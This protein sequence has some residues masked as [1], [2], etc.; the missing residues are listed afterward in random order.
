MK[1]IRVQVRGGP[2]T[3]LY[4]I[5]TQD[6]GNIAAKYRMQRSNST[7]NQIYWIQCPTCEDWM[8]TECI[9]NNVC[10]HDRTEL[11]RSDACG[12]EFISRD[13]VQRTSVGRIFAKVPIE[14]MAT[15]NETTP[16]M[17]GS[18]DGNHV[19]CAVY[20]PV[21]PVSLGDKS[22]TEGKGIIGPELPKDAGRTIGPELPPG[23]VTDD[24]EE[25]DCY[26][27]AL[28]PAAESNDS[29]RWIGPSL[30]PDLDLGN[31]QNFGPTPIQSEYD[32]IG[33]MPVANVDKEEQ[34]L[35]YV[36]RRLELESKNAEEHKLVREEWI[37]KMPKQGPIAG[38]T[39]RTFKRTKDTS[40][41][42]E[43]WEDTPKT[44]RVMTQG[45]EP[46]SGYQ[47]QKKA[48]T[49]QEHESSPHESLVEMH[50]KKREK[51][52]G[53]KLT[54]NSGERVPFNRDQDMGYCGKPAASAEELKKRAGELSARFG[55]KN[56]L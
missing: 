42:D 54:T 53:T 8:H 48:V 40:E 20:G 29:K 47:E 2:R 23:F 25:D 44:K 18:E 38:L 45:K 12:L 15:N 19:D 1:K 4:F 56:Y 41:L 5:T 33:P 51:A 3:R 24:T 26:G 35:E 34:A 27:P 37:T 7:N 6:I 28:P 30:P 46:H 49:D 32:D 43:S 50:M 31:D 17:S 55:S 11:G 10:P 16:L 14:E 9:S 21:L 36:K 52:S 39:A 22:L 13:L